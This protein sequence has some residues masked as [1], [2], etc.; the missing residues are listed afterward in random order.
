MAKYS[1]RDFMKKS[2]AMGTVA[3]A[4]SPQE[5]KAASSGDVRTERV[6]ITIDGDRLRYNKMRVEVIPGDRVEWVCTGHPFSIHFPGVTPVREISLKNT[7]AGSILVEIP[8]VETV[9]GCFKYFV[10]VYDAATTKV[11]TDDPDIIVDPKPKGRGG[12]P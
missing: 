6:Q 1:R 8:S 4:V 12:R 2:A 3:L 9:Y 11:L 7:G 5:G 10:A